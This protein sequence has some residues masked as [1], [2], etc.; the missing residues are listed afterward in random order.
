MIIKRF[1]VKVNGKVIKNL[2]KITKI[3]LSP[4]LGPPQSLERVDP[5]TASYKH[6]SHKTF[7]EYS[8]YA[9]RVNPHDAEARKMCQHVSYRNVDDPGKNAV[10]KKRDRCFSSRPHRKIAA[11][12]KTVEGQRKCHDTDQL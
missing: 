10:E 7:Y 5:E 2:R 8:G 4:A 1:K 9:E 3:T 12:G 6:G 11:M